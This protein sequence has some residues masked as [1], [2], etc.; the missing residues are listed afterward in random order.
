ME[1]ESSKSAPRKPKAHWYQFRLRTL[2]LL[3]TLA[4]VVAGWIE[5]RQY[6]A[7]LDKEAER[8]EYE[9]PPQPKPKPKAVAPD[10]QQSEPSDN[11]P[12]T[13]G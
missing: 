5:W 1:L 13:K 3:V 12:R 6:K 2:M 7:S 9:Y 8:I 10:R 11:P 4:C